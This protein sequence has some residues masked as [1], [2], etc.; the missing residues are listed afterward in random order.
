MHLERFRGLLKNINELVVEFERLLFEG[1]TT[2]YV[3]ESD[4]SFLKL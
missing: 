3:S 4:S 2:V 1:L